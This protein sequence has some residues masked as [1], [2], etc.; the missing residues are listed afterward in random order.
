MGLAVSMVA[1]LAWG[2]SPL[3]SFKDDLFRYPEPVASRD[4]GAYLD[5][6]YDEARDI[7]RR[8]EIPE[9]QVRRA[10]VDLSAG[11][12]REETVTTSKGSVRVLKVGRDQ[13]PRL[14]VAFMHG[15]SGDR[16]LGMNDWT[17]GGN[18]NRLKSLVSRA[19]GLYLTI[20]GGAL[21]A[22]DAARFTEALVTIAD[23]S[24]NAK[25][26]L[27]CGS[28][29]GALCW[30]AMGEPALASRV[31]GLVLLGSN[32]TSAEFDR[33]LAA[34]KG[35]PLPL[36][37]SQGSRDKVYP[38]ASQERFYETVRQRPGYPIRFVA[39][40]GGNHGTP[41]RMIDWRDALNWVIGNAGHQ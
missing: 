18:F 20:D 38:L 30:R 14:I 23:R 22:D 17:F 13:G 37:I 31:S 19:G 6:P 41:I 40:D 3:A 4:E 27:A 12:A 26:V 10:Y 35:A 39:F 2:Q 21:G 16:R 34:R 5:V 32:S 8:D 9:R 33:A 36:V 29:G 15:R 25:L 24:P 7:D 28:M 1:T 11:D